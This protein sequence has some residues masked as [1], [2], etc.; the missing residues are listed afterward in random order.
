MQGGAVLGREELNRG[1][2]GSCIWTKVG[3][4]ERQRVHDDEEP[5]GDGLDLVYGRCQ[6]D[7]N[8]GHDGEAWTHMH[9]DTL[10]AYRLLQ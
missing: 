2:E 3:E 9:I 4:E 1:D 5:D 8:D 7:Q 6:D 10:S